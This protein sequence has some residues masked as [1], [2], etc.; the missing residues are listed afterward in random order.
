VVLPFHGQELAKNFS[1]IG[2][3]VVKEFCQGI[4]NN[5]PKV[6]LVIKLVL[7]ENRR[8][9]FQVKKNSEVKTST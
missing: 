4:G 1:E 8:T 5:I 7:L 6:C 3:N 9:I 2:R